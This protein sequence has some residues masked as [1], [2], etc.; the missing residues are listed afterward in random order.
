MELPDRDGDGGQGNASCTSLS[1]EIIMKKIGTAICRLQ[2]RSLF[3]YK[4]VGGRE[5][6]NNSVHNRTRK[7]SEE[8]VERR[9][10][11]ST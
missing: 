11:L 10:N 1:L 6:F 5:T 8:E 7:Q 2:F 9:S 4:V 3:S